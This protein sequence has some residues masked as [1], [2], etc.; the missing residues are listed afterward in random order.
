VSARTREPNVTG[1]AAATA[2][3]A[4]MREHLEGMRT[5]TAAAIRLHGEV[6]AAAALAM[7]LLLEPEWDRDALASALAVALVRL[8]V[9]ASP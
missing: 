6:R 8:A 9:E 5:A 3:D 1:E 4:A 2:R 7:V